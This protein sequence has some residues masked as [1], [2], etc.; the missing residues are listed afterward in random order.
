[1]EFH[2]L[3]KTPLTVA[4]PDLELMGVGRGGGETF[5]LACPAGFSSAILFLPKIRGPSLR[6]ATDIHSC[7]MYACQLFSESQT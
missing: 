7:L 3:W 4:D 1:M 6:S 2:F 5:C